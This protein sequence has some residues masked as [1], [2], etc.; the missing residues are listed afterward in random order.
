MTRELL[1]LMNAEQ[2]QEFARLLGAAER[3][4]GAAACTLGDMYREGLEGLRYSP[5]ETY[6]W[7]AKSALTGDA[8][9]QNNSGACYEHGLGCAQSY[10]KAAK[11]Y[12]LA[13]A[14]G[15]AYASSNLGYLYLR[16][17]GVP[18][19]KSTALG[20]F[21][22][23]LAQGDERAEQEIE[24]LKHDRDVVRLAIVATEPHPA[25][26]AAC[27]GGHAVDPAT[28]RS[29]LRCGPADSSLSRRSSHATHPCVLAPGAVPR[30]G[31]PE[32]LRH[33]QVA[34][35]ETTDALCGPK[36]RVVECP[37]DRP[38]ATSESD[39]QSADRES[40]RPRIR[41][42]DAVDVGKNFGIVGTGG[43][44]PPRPAPWEDEDL[45]R[46]L[47]GTLRAEKVAQAECA[48]GPSEEVLFPI[49]AEGG[50]KPDDLVDGIAERYAEYLKDRAAE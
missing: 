21:E 36:S 19:D 49:L 8:N 11:W 47:L 24:R 7:Y 35:D 43:V 15:L 16:G 20:W 37:A 32:Q 39:Q 38:V 23:A 14:Q 13:A 41:Y 42:L 29:R 12:R 46:E 48:D 33:P 25:N 30:D 50:L 4:D 27:P 34:A 26:V 18:A 28:L 9:G 1:F 6:R 5:K 17:H 44:Q 45:R 22:K 2:A 3:G 10:A 40:A 31:P